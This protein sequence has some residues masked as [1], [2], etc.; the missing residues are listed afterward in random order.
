MRLFLTILA[1]DIL[2]I[3][4]VAA[5]G[6]VLA[7]RLRVDV[8]SV[9]RVTFNAL[10]PCLVFT[11]L[12]TSRVGAGEFG[13]IVAFTILLV[14]SA[15]AVARLAAIPFRLERPALAAFLIVVMFSNSAN[16]GL[17]VVLFAFG[18]EALSRAVVYFATGAMLVYS[19]GS[20]LASSGR[21]S[22]REAAA[23]LLRV[24]ALWGLLAAA[25]VI[26][27]GATLP[28]FVLRPATLL[29]S[30]AIPTMLLVLGMQFER[31]AWPERP[32]LVATAALLGLVGSPLIGFGLAWLLGLEGVSRQAVLVEA[33]MPSAVI[34]TIL[35]VE[36]DVEPRFVTSVVVVT[37]LASAVTVSILIALLKSGY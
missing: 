2:P 21:R 36:F 10:A 24:P 9:S 30:A 17:S 4:L 5:V 31:G 12:V 18:E 1:D 14:G 13:R 37:T 32:A 25:V 6:F 8:K 23:G 19:V 16:Y 28:A 27:T 35:A 34:T 29:S 15:G 26:G 11:Q 33:A 3:F 20:F 22:A 7:R